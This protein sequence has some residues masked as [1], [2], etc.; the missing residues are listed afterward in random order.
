MP[1]RQGP[2]AGGRGDAGLITADDRDSIHDSSTRVK[3]L[4]HRER[5]RLIVALALRVAKCYLAG[6]SNTT[7][8][9]LG[10]RK[11]RPPIDDEPLHQV[12]IR[13]TDDQVAW[14]DEASAA[15][16]RIGRN[17]VVRLLLDRARRRGPLDI[18][19]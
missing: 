7:T 12:S 17:A 10:A 5:V 19:D 11:G 14:L 16:G 18:P 2:R 3:P 1:Q 6:M 13:L 15:L 4:V 8:L 9:S